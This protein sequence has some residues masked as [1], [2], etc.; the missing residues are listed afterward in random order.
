[1]KGIVFNVFEKFIVENHGQDFFEDV[2][3]ECEL[4]TDGAFVGPGTYPDSD[5][6]E[7]V[8]KTI[9][10]AGIPLDA[11][12]KAF[13]QYLFHELVKTYPVFVDSVSSLKDFLKSVDG[14]IHVEVNKLYP[15]AITPKFEYNEPSDDV[16]EIKYSS[17]RNLPD[18]FEG[19]T[20]GAAEHYKSEIEMNRVPVDESK[21]IWKFSIKF[22]D[23]A[24]GAA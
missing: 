5:L 17:D 7:I 2:L 9:A 6:L 11:A 13:G 19:L 21:G 15:E 20:N 10:K 14:V 24:T 1:M 12:L 23:A 4:Q 22:C 8:S 16:L 18:L 3:D